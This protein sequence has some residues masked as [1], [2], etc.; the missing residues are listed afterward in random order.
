MSVNERLQALPPGALQG[1]DPAL[2][3][4]CHQVRRG[5]CPERTAKG[6]PF[7][8][9]R[10]G[11]DLQHAGALLDAEAQSEE[12]EDVFLPVARRSVGLVGRHAAKVG[13]RGA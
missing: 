6:A 4:D 5:S 13:A 7:V 11:G 8:L 1:Q 2:I 10:G 12:G 3:G 9:D